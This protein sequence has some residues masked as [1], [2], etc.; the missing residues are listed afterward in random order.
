MVQSKARA[1][2]DWLNG[3]AASDRPISDE[4]LGGAG[5]DYDGWPSA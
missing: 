5:D 3:L 1:V 2:D 4:A